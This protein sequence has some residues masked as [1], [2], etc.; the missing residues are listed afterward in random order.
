MGLICYM[1]GVPHRLTVTIA[2]RVSKYWESSY[3]DDVAK[4]PTVV[5]LFTV[6]RIKVLV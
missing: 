5:S 3:T 2:V 1:T 4:R 6:R